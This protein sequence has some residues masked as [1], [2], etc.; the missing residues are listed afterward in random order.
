ME[1]IE[2]EIKSHL[3]NKEIVDIEFF[4][5]NDSYLV[6]NP[7]S[8]WVF[9]G[10]IQIDFA[11]AVF[12]FGWD[13][14]SEGFD[15]SMENAID[16]F[17]GDEPFFPAEAK[18]IPGISKLVGSKIT[19]VNIKWDYYQNMDEEGEIIPEKIFIPVELLLKFETGDALQLALIS[20][21]IQDEPFG[22]MDVEFN[23][24]GELLI[25]LNDEVLIKETSHQ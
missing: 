23:Q 11:D 19:E 13:Y 14:E 2:Q 20:Y 4:N 17:F 12:S 1:N 22:L 21:Q 8:K 24:S 15:F 7:E 18:Q 10:G 6:L 16:E 25:A 9:D 3:L 5:V